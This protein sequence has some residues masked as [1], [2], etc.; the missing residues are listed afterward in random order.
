[1]DDSKTLQNARDQVHLTVATLPDYKQ[2]ARTAIVREM[3]DNMHMASNP[4][5]KDRVDLGVSS[6]TEFI[7]MDCTGPKELTRLTGAS[8]KTVISVDYNDLETLIEKVYGHAYEI[9]PM[10]EVGSSQYA[11]TYDMNVSTGKL[12]EY[13]LKELQSLIDGNPK[14]YMLSTIM[15]DLAD[16][17]HLDVGE[18]IIDVNW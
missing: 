18:Y 1:M 17:G 6:N 13:E 8:V 14:K 5:N 10:E 16:K 11:A 4:Q 7:E 9:M 3:V 12:N 2:E 15:K